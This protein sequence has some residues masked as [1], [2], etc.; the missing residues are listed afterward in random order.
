M[1]LLISLLLVSL[2]AC[3]TNPPSAVPDQGAAPSAAPD[4]GATAAPAP[5]A[6]SDHPTAPPPTRPPLYLDAPLIE[7][8]ES[9]GHFKLGMKQ[10]EIIKAGHKLEAP[11]SG[12][13]SESV[14]VSGPFTLVFGEDRS[15]T[16][17][18]LDLTRSSLRYGAG[19]DHKIIT[20]KTPVD[21]LLKLLGCGELEI[22]EGGNVARCHNGTLFKQAGPILKP[23]VQVKREATGPT[24]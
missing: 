11:P 16:S 24:P 15:L 8:G 21:E 10:E 3:Q 7:L 4:S 2:C 9:I 1:K 23:S 18:E 13:L 5:D 22:M 17:I 19:D 14:K 6:A 20:D 12:Q